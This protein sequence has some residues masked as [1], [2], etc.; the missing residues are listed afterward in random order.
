M[1]AAKRSLKAAIIILGLF[2][3]VSVSHGHGDVQPQAVDITG[4]KELGKEWLEANPYTKEKTPDQIRR[5]IEIGC[6]AYNSNCARCHGLG[7]ISG[8][9][10]PDLRYLEKDDEG[11]LWYINRVRQG[12]SQNGLTKMP[13]FEGLMAQEAMW[14]IRAYIN[15]RPEDDDEAVVKGTGGN[16]QTLDYDLVLKTETN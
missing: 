7:V 14:S 1:Q 10:A 12:Y 2:G 4:L 8:G 15:I 9:T 3:M 5:A 11:D 13:A 16:C 6:S